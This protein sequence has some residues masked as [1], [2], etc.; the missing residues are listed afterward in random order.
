MALE[1][2]WRWFGDND[3]ITLNHIKQ[4]GVEGI[5]TSLHH[6]DIGE[7]WSVEEIKAVYN[8][9]TNHGLKWSVV[10]SL[11]VAEG[12]KLHAPDYD[13]LISNYVKSL[14]NLSEYGINKVCYN[15][16]PVLD[17]A[18]TDLDYTL[19]SGGIVMNFDYIKF[20]AFD[21]FLL[22]R[23]GAE[24][25]YDDIIKEKASVLFDKMIPAEKES[26]AYNIIVLTQ[27]F[28][29][30]NVTDEKDYKSRF[31][32]LILNYSD[33]DRNKYRENLKSFLNDVIP[34]A[35]KYEIELAIHPDDPPFPLLG[36]PRIVGTIDDLDW[37]FNSN[38]SSFN[39]FTFCSGSLSVSKDNIYEIAK[40]FTNRIK[41]AHLRNNIT[42]SEKT[43][44]ESGHITGDLDMIKLVSILLEEQ[45]RRIAH[46]DHNWR[47]PVRPDHG[48]AFIDDQNKNYPPGYP[49][50]G[51][52]KGLAEITGIEQ[53]LISKWS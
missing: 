23:P 37:I 2:T 15:F 14:Q 28:I 46:N 48:I 19:P 39:G 44:H 30:G 29:N 10:E 12:I 16:M 4:I 33:I 27:S 1:K 45:K 31:L 34:F 36:L 5:V 53:G 20:A 42:T 32:D 50:I 43:F 49:F 18:R 7:I 24:K 22:K 13:R 47:I 41:F 9:I 25:D 35:E 6:K 8:N 40:R 17:W 26:L 38:K 52:L 3:S 21:L 51:R 11:P